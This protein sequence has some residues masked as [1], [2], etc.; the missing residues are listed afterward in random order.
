MV[1]R[2]DLALI[3]LNRI[4]VPNMC[5][6]TIPHRQ[7]EHLIEITVIE[8]AIPTDGKGV[9]AH[10]A[11]RGGGIEGVGQSFHILF[12]VAALH[13]E[14]EK[15]ADRHVGDRIE[16]V[17][18]DTMAGSKFFPKLCLDGLLAGR[19]KG[20]YWIGDQV[21]SETAIGAAISQYI[22]ES[23][24]FDGFLKDAFSPLR[25]GLAG[26]E[27]GQRRDDFHTMAS[28]ELCQIRLRREE[29]DGQ[30]TSIHHVATE[31]PAL[32]DQPA[33]VRIEFWGSPRNVDGGNVGLRQSLDTALRRFPGHTLGPI[34]PRIN[35]TVATGLI[36]ELADID[37]KDGDPGGTKRAQADVIELGYEGGT[38]R[39]PSENFQL[40][41][42]GSERV[43]LSDQGQCHTVSLL[44]GE[45]GGSRSMH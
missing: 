2:R 41:Q 20:S 33:K 1:A 3:E 28:K 17:E 31:R 34:G 22:Q 23:Q 5:G 15:P 43:M 30:V 21:Q 13:E 38:T 24:G 35:V 7:I 29:Q 9:T 11:C 8:G 27:I 40:F 26:A 12:V 45:S 6:C 10:D 44:N 19:E 18:L 25:I 32:F 14:L 37:L 16:M 36:A 42:G 4:E 39:R